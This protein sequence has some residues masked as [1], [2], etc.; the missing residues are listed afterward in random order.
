MA[1]P[2]SGSISLDGRPLTS[3]SK[4]NLRDAMSIIP[5]EPALIET[6]LRENLD[7]FGEHDDAAIWSALDRVQAAA[8]VRRLPDGLDTAITGGAT[9]QFSRGERQLL[10]LAT[11]ALRRR[12]ICCLDESTASVDLATERAIQTA[13]ATGFEDTTVIIVVRQ[14][15]CSQSDRTGA[16]HLDDPGLRPGRRDERRP[17]DRDRAAARAAH[18]AGQSLCGAGGLARGR[19]GRLSCTLQC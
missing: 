13:L 4:R 7:P 2:Q 1:E 5:Q 14:S 10:A 16:P 18:A 15:R 6:S 11:C 12:R 19:Q 9:G 3:L 8:T 17:A